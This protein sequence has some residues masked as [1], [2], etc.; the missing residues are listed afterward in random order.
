MYSSYTYIKHKEITN[1]TSNLSKY[2]YLSTAKKIAYAIKKYPSHNYFCFDNWE[3]LNLVVFHLISELR[4]G[5]IIGKI[6]WNEFTINY[7]N[8]N[9]KISRGFSND[10]QMKF[11]EIERI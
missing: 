7:K 2:P 4:E 1:K 10:L 9:Y 11:Y 3:D 8:N 6:G 5:E